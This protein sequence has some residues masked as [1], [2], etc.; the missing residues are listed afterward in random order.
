VT[1]TARAQQKRLTT[2]RIA[3]SP[4]DRLLATPTDGGFG[5]WLISLHGEAMR[6]MPEIGSWH[7]YVAG[8]WLRDDAGAVVELAKDAA[9]VIIQLIPTEQSE[10]RQQEMLRIAHRYDCVDRL[11]RVLDYLRSDERLL[12]RLAECDTDPYLLNCLNGTV[13]LRDARLLVHSPAHRLTKTTGIVYDPHAPCPIFEAFLERITRAHSELS[14]FLRRAFG[15]TLLGDVRE[16]RFFLLLGRG[17]NGKSTLVEIVLHVLGDYAQ[18]SSA[19]TWLRQQSNRGAEPDIARLPGV[20]M[21]ATAEIGEGRAIDEARIK[22]I[23]AGDRTTTRTIYREPFEF[24]PV[25][26][27]WISTN[28]APTIK[29]SDEGMWRRVCLVPFDDYISDDELD[30]DLSRKLRD[31]ASGILAWMVRGAVAYLRDGLHEPDVVR[32]ATSEYRSDSDLVGQYIDQR[33]DIVPGCRETAGRLH[34]DYMVWARD[35]GERPLTAV[36]FGRRLTER[37]YVAEKVGGVQ[38]RAGLRLRDSGDTG[39]SWD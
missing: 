31:E 4:L 29:G 7:V 34:R 9:K 12:M 1:Q 5:E 36:S 26:K 19:E 27:L 33:C 10:A 8:R 17:R 22:S 38:W 14:D 21:T 6:Y 30:R 24:S 13:D 32:A 15:Y 37:G 20:R 23:V 39:S 16:H 35:R 3:A 2:L 11:R 18:S 28:H 25:C